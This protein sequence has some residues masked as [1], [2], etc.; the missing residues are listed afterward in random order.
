MYVFDSHD[1]DRAAKSAELLNRILS[2]ESMNGIPL[3]VCANKMDM[4]GAMTVE[5][6]TEALGLNNLKDRVWSVQA[7]STIKGEGLWESLDW[8]A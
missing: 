2:Y 1:V 4:P 8:F 5:E 3:L 7:A 6:V